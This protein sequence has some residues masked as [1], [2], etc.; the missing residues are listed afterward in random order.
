MNI[1]ILLAYH[2]KDVLFKDDVLTPV[3]VGRDIAVQK[4]AND[5]NLQWLIDNTIGDN[6]GENISDKNSFYNELTAIFWAWKNYESIGNPDYLGFMHYRRHFVFKQSDRPIYTTAEDN[7]IE[8]YFKTINYDREVLDSLLK[9]CDFISPSP[10]YHS[11][12]VYNMYA[13]AHYIND[14]DNCIDIINKKFPDFVDDTEEYLRGNK[15]YYYNMF[16]FDKETFFEYCEFIFS[17]C[18]EL[19]NFSSSR[20]FVSERLTGIFITHLINKGKKGK[21]LPVMVN[22]GK[23]IIPVVMASDNNGKFPLIVA[24]TSLLTTAHK[25]TSYD[26]HLLLSKDVNDDFRA[27]INEIADKFPQHKIK[28][29][30]GLGE[31]F[32]DLSLNISHV[33]TPTFYRLKLPEVLSNVKKCIY[34]DIDVIVRKDLSELF[35]LNVDDK[36]IAG[37]RAAGY[38]YPEDKARD[39]SSML[40]IDDIF[41]YVN[42]GVLLINLEAMRKNGIPK[43]FNELT[44]RNFPSMDQDILNSACYGKIR[45]INPMYNLMTKYNPIDDKSYM[46]NKGLQLSYTLKEWNNARKNPVIIHFA[47]KIKP[48]DDAKS[49]MANLWWDVAKKSAFFKD[50]LW[51]FRKI[52]SQDNEIVEP[53]FYKQK[54]DYLKNNLINDIYNTLS[55]YRIDIKLKKG[56]C[57]IVCNGGKVDR[58]SWFQKNDG[59][60]YIVQSQSKEL[61]VNIECLNDGVLELAFRTKDVKENGKRINYLVDAKYI[62]INDVSLV[63]DGKLSFSHDKPFKYSVSVRKGDVVSIV[64]ISEVHH[65]EYTE[66]RNL[67]SRMMS[68]SI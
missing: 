33:T 24:L 44:Q 27:K 6:S 29:Y 49:C 47:D 57:E 52:I 34:L 5:G 58:P 15:S 7:D 64:C 2:K 1:K 48:W 11:D 3:H 51:Y 61:I 30:V 59:V 18:F 17:V 68:S 10:Q 19:K 12:S 54:L 39:T 22:E 8:S 38:Y 66:F 41:S 63:S 46:K 67:L 9:D 40:N 28:L 45:I 65:Y 60:G 62:S 20:L 36:Y 50:I 25:I 53:E 35:R 16:I 56:D 14:L 13:D 43:I 42:A 37:V 4:S 21:F 31:E 26:V 32:S 55:T 23:H